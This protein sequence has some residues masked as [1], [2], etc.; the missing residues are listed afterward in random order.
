MI[1][2]FPR[3]Q[4]LGLFVPL[5]CFGNQVEKKMEHFNLA[6]FAR[7]ALLPAFTLVPFKDSLKYRR[8]SRKIWN[9]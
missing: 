1:V 5:H 4:D 8:K 2:F 7:I 9:F 3:A 6:L